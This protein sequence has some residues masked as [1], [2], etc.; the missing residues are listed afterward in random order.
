[1]DRLPAWILDTPLLE[2]W[3]TPLCVAAAVLV[4]AGLW[5]WRTRRLPRAA[6]AGLLLVPAVLAVAG[7]WWVNRVWAPFADGVAPAVFAWAGLALLVLGQVLAG[8]WRP[9]PGRWGLAGIGAA[10]V[11]AL[12]VTLG[13]N[14]HYCTYESLAVMTGAHVHWTDW[15]TARGEEARTVVPAS[16]WTPP[17]GLPEHGTVSTVPLP[18]SDP[19]FS[20]RDA[21]VYLPPAYHAD[22]RPALPVL[23]L[24]AG[25]PGTPTDWVGPGRAAETLDAYAAAH[26]GLAPI[27]VSVD[28]LGGSLVNPLCS[29]GPHGDVA[30]YVARDVPAWV[31]QTLQVDPDRH[32]WTIGGISNGATCALQTVART[33]DAY[34]SVLVLSGELHPDLGGE[35]RTISEGFGGD[36]AAYEAND[37]LSLF[38]QAE[39]GRGP[40]ARG[41]YRSV[42]GIVSVG[43]GDRYVGMPVP[44]ELAGSARRAGL[45]LQLR[46]YPGG[47]SWH[48][49]SR[50]FEDQ[51]PWAAQRM[52]LR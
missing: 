42:Q 32:H 15:D 16:S 47:H 10:A 19:S 50:A 36:R 40:G 4:A 28:P 44:R 11:T 21:V 20:P 34:G 25:V 26:G 35:E 1:M 45:D 38:A 37:P 33:P 18:A 46:T 29:D 12:T 5:W 51:L 48:V 7:W 27:L 2:P 17:P 39:H 14:A 23:V 49:W 41:A 9:H 24:M 22:P 43:Q 30:A 13:V 52:G 8:P 6:Q 31:E 3:M